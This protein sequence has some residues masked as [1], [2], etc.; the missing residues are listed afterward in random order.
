M[1][2][3]TVKTLHN[4]SNFW[5]FVKPE[6]SISRSHYPT[7]R[8][9][10][11]QKNQVTLSPYLTSF[12]PPYSPKYCQWP[13]SL[14]L[15]LAVAGTWE[16]R[17]SLFVTSNRCIPHSDILG[18]S[19][20]VFCACGIIQLLSVVFCD[21]RYAHKFYFRLF[22]NEASNKWRAMKRRSC[23]DRVSYFRQGI[24]ICFPPTVV[25]R[26]K[27]FYPHHEGQLHPLE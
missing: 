8:L 7:A 4:R 27:V 10:T 18:S 14:Q 21:I 26:S 23:S 12:T 13:W 17:P 6:H 25:P 11:D 5:H 1:P 24:S 9:L 20:V 19:A 2:Y 15:T 22:I 16:R 3:T